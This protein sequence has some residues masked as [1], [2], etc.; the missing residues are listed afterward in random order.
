MAMFP[1]FIIGLIVGI[2]LGYSVTNA[3]AKSK[4]TMPTETKL[5]IQE[6]ELIALREDNKSLNR[7]VDKLYEKID[8]LTADSSEPDEK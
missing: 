7:L 5:H 8:K 2:L 6:A 3:I 4:E 1:V